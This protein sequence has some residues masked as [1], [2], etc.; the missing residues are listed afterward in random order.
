MSF[1]LGLTKN[2]PKKNFFDTL[3]RNRKNDNQIKKNNKNQEI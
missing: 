2:R 3:Q 1:F